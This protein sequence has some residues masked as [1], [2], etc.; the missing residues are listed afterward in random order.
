MCKWFQDTFSV[1]VYHFLED[2]RTGY[3]CAV[4]QAPKTARSIRQRGRA[5][6][7][8]KYALHLQNFLLKNSSHRLVVTKKEAG[9]L[10][11]LVWYGGSARCPDRAA[12]PMRLDR[13]VWS[14]YRRSE[15]TP[16]HGEKCYAN[17]TVVLS[18][19]TAS[20][21][22]ASAGTSLL[23]KNY[24]SNPIN[25]SGRSLAAERLPG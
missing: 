3:R 7:T 13:R 19:W 5:W 10:C 16:Q 18:I 17:K 24:T 11:P 15:I 4:R 20:T 8:L 12:E 9:A 1:L 25:L 14:L 22:E 23:D 6:E 2:Q 21:L